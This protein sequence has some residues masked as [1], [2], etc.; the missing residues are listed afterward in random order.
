MKTMLGIDYGLKHIGLAYA[1]GPL[2]RPLITLP[3]DATLFPKL[4][5]IALDVRAQEL[6]IGIPE[7][8]LEN[9]VI[10]F[11]EEVKL[12]LGLPVHLHEETLTTKT[13]LA[14]LREIGAKRKKLANDHIYSACLIL[15]DYLDLNK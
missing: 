9:V 13:A 8:R 14:N 5:Q 15:E 11:A 3:N 10:K 6:V 4:K 2:A 7:G 1:D 12:A